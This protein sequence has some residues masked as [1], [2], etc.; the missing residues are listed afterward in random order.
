M[1]YKY[2]HFSNIMNSS[3]NIQIG[4]AIRSYLE[5]K[6]LLQKDVAERLNIT[7]GAV[8]AYYRGKPFGK[9]AAKKWADLFGFRVNWLLTGE[10]DM[11]ISSQPKGTAKSQPAQDT[12]IIELLKEQNAD[13]Q[14]K[15]DALNQ[16]IG[17]LKALL[18]KEAETV[19]S[20]RASFSA[21]AV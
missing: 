18:K 4:E 5:S 1:F 11:L 10:G 9:N 20:A 7:Q 6:G 13:L 19:G 8:S 16:Q 14:A 12:R 3:I 17:E 2:N 15:V 21:N